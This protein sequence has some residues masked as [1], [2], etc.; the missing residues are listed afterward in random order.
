MISTFNKNTG[1][2]SSLRE[3]AQSVLNQM[4]DQ[5]L[6]PT[7]LDIKSL[8]EEL[9]IHQIE[10]EMQNDELQQTQ[11]KLEETQRYLSDL[12][13]Y[14]PVGYVV[15]DPDGKIR[16]VNRSGSEYLNYS[17]ELL[18]GLRIQ[19]FV[20]P[21]SIVTYSK[22]IKKL[23]ET[24]SPQTAE[25][26][27]RKRGGE[28][29]WAR[30]DMFIIKEQMKDHTMILCSLLDITNEK[31]AKDK[32]GVQ[33]AEVETLVAKRTWELKWE[34][35]V[36]MST[37]E[38]L[39]MIICA[40]NIEEISMLVNDTAR[41]LTESKFGYVGYID[42]ETGYMI[43]PTMTRDI[44]DTCKMPNTEK[45]VVFKKFS[46]L[47]GWVLINK[48]PILTNDV[49]SDPR[50]TGVPIGHIALEKV[51][52][53]PAIIENQLV[54]QITLANPERNYTERDLSLTQRL[55]AI[56]AIAIRHKRNEASLI[57]AKEAAEAASY[58]KS[59]FLANMSHEIRTPMNSIIGMAQLL[60]E[61]DLKEEQ[62]EYATII[63]SSS[64]SLLTL[65]NDILDLSKI[66]AGKLD[67]V[68]SD[69]N[70]HQTIEKV[71]S[72]LSIIAS[73]KNLI[74]SSKIHPN[75]P[76]YVRGDETRLHQ[77]LLNLVNNAIK[78]TD[79]GS[80]TVEA[81]LV[82]Q[83]DGQ[84]SIQFRVSDT[85]IGISEE[86]MAYLFKPFSQIDASSKR[87]HSGT[88][89][90]LSISKQLIELMGGKI[91]VQSRQGEGSTFVFTVV[92]EIC[93]KSTSIKP[94]KEVPKSIQFDG[95]RVLVVEDNV[96]N[97]KLMVKMLKKLGI[98]SD[99]AD[100]GKQ[101]LQLLE[102]KPYDLVLMDIQMPEMDGVET[103][104][105][106]RQSSNPFRNIPI[107]A[108]T[109]NVMAEDRNIYLTAGMNDYISKPIIPEALVQV[110]QQYAKSKP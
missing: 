54:G 109:A 63:L 22:C 76:T 59:M 4:K 67:L 60:A 101:A 24:H 102:S 89:L 78:F 106:I 72:I 83:K 88:G 90:G 25:I 75:V 91:Q 19:T 80:V 84:A 37:A 9:H 86:H 14:A 55:A 39:E 40:K 26:L 44:W 105:L 10:L 32:L 94:K 45:N 87:K 52:S 99:T 100:S 48:E 31:R 46:G 79:K 64:K 42:P 92:L 18:V 11:I 65:L 56:Y 47:W 108:L 95:V 57:K 33:L 5:T 15:L 93:D 110:L 103:T 36:N 41:R 53:V 96:F 71:I 51:L 1:K 21:D 7:N 104:K 70:L 28:R 30:I 69:F 34:S 23:S 43:T 66:E 74:L 6:L 98:E 61:T 8:L 35:D 107:I 97:Q 2:Y 38:L 29:F 17:K 50:S 49:K 27:F 85:G 73:E 3:R 58:A 16:D 13:M 62:R 12:F 77:V 20:D 68:I 81:E 82:S